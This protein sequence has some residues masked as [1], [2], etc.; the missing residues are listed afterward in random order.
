MRPGLRLR[1]LRWGALRALDRANP[2]NL[3]RSWAYDRLGRGRLSADMAKP[4]C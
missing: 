4:L 3:M 2:L 1:R